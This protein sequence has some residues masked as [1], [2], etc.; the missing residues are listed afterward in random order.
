VPEKPLFEGSVTDP[1]RDPGDPEPAP[2][3]APADDE[4]RRLLDHFR[5]RLRDLGASDD[6]MADVEEWWDTFDDEWTPDYRREVALE[7]SDERIARDVIDVRREEAAARPPDTTHQEDDMAE[8]DTV[9]GMAAQFMDEGA[10]IAA[11]MD[12]VGDDPA[13]ARAVLDAELAKGEDG[14]RSTLVARL[15]GLT[16]DGA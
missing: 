5:A 12:W 6:E 7:W 4:G 8:G 2:A 1:F 3:P 10:T 13:R 14:A 16:G 15:E 11:I 9:E